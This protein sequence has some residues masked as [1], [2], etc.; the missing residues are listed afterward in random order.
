MQN[1]TTVSYLLSDHLGSTTALTDATGVVTNTATYDGFGNATG[2]LNTRYG[3]TGREFDADLGLQYSRARFYD[4]K[5]GRFIS[6]DPIG[7]SG[8]DVNLFGYVHNNAV[9]KTD[10]LGLFDT[11]NYQNAQDIARAG[12]GAVGAGGGILAYGGTSVAAAPALAVG[13]VIA[14]GLATGY[15]IGYF[16]GQ[17]IAQRLY[18]E[19]FPDTS[20]KTKPETSCDSEPKPTPFVPF[21]P[22][23]SSNTS[24]TPKPPKNNCSLINE[25]PVEKRPDLKVCVYRCRKAMGQLVFVTQYADQ[26]CPS[27]NSEGWITRPPIPGI[28]PLN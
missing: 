9:N 7:F 12:A 10:P 13:A 26:S 11:G 28:Y 27:E 19:Q 8:G 20:P 18:P 24:T 15:A 21:V 25:I 6:E 17:Y 2:N 1:G 23:S 14:E 5:L 16:P 4:A 3:Y 22:L